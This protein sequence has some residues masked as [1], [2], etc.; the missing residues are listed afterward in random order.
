MAR[1]TVSKA[2]VHLWLTAPI[3][4]LVL[5]FAPIPAW[6]VEEY[7]SRDVYPWLQR[8]LTTASNLVDLALIDLLIAALF[9]LLL[10]RVTRLA[11]LALHVS[12]FDALSEAGRRVLRAVGI[13]AIIFLLVW[14]FNYRRRPLEEALPGGAATRPDVA[15]LQALITE[16]DALAARLRSRGDV[17]LQ[18]SYVQTKA[19]L[20]LPMNVALEELSRT[21]LRPVGRPKFS[22]LLNPFFTAAGVN[23]MLDPFVLESI[24][25]PDL[26]PVERPF[27]VAH[28]WAHMAGHGDEAEASAIGWLACMKSTPTA[29]YS[30][31]LYVIMEAAS[32]L[33]D[34]VRQRVLERLD[35]GVRSDIAAISRRMLKQNPEIQRAASRVYGKYLEANRVKDG[36]A[37]Y[38]RALSLIMTSPIRDALGAYGRSMRTGTE[39][40]KVPAG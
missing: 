30:A 21:P 31:N 39:K 23:G 22:I 40:G 15:A 32:V 19:D 1:A 13:V 7:Y 37:S 10:F 24:V 34:G 2:P 8:G 38:S 12:A 36:V 27:V 3:I 28:E 20:E 11:M 9:V 25:Q 4:A 5:F 29:V 18:I 26:V 35:A 16:S 33:P 14:G 6:A 17:K